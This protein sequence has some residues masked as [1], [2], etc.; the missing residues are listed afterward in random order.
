MTRPRRPLSNSA[1]TASWSLRPHPRR[2]RALP[3]LLPELADAVHRH[4]GLLL[5]PGDLAGVDDHV[6]LEVQDLLQL[7]ERHVEELPD[8]AGQSLEEPDVGDGGGQLDVAHALAA[9]PGARDLHPAL[10]A[11][12]AG[13]L[14]ALVLAAGALVVLG[15]AEDPRAE[16]AVALGLE[17]PVVDGLGLLHLAVGPVTNLLRRGQLDPDRAERHG[18]RMPIEEAPQVLHGLLLTY[19]AAERPV[20]QHSSN[21]LYDG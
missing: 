10:V 9:H 7:P 1:S 11:D 15:R 6:L 19:Q 8:A 12:H 20:R 13:E 4:E 21:L 14:H 5:E 17:R 3:V 2:E 18:L 16:Q